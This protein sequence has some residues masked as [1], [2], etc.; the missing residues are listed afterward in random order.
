MLTEHKALPYVL[1]PILTIHGNNHAHY[2]KEHD[3]Q[4]FHVR[5]Y[6]KDGYLIVSN[7]KRPMLEPN[8]GTG[9]GLSNLNS[10]YQLLLNR[11]IEI[12]DNDK[13]FTVCLPLEKPNE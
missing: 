11:K 4:L 10:R 2:Y 8:Q 13:E 6:T 1:Q 12:V 9:L 5:I 3:Q 7:E